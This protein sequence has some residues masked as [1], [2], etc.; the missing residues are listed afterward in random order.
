MD[1]LFGVIYKKKSNNFFNSSPHKETR[2]YCFVS[3][4]LFSQ[5]FSQFLD[6][7]LAV[8]MEFLDRKLTVL[9]KEERKKGKEKK[10]EGKERKKRSND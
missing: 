7:K 1:K 5:D 6:F 10:R 9:L 3:V 2:E 4:S 8:L